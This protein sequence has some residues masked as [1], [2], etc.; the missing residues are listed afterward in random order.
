[1]RWAFILTVG[2]LYLGTV[3]FGTYLLWQLAKQVAS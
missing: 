3:A 2:P 1:M